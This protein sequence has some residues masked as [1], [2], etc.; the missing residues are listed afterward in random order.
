MAKTK[1]YQKLNPFN[2]VVFYFGF[3]SVFNLIFW[4]FIFISYIHNR[5]KSIEERKE[6][7]AFWVFVFG[8]II[9]VIIA[10]L[11]MTNGV[12]YLFFE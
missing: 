8:W 6:G 10:Y 4:L 5:R 12:Y 2:K 1:F 11:L 3:L 7:Y 9:F